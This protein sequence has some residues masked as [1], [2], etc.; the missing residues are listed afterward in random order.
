MTNNSKLIDATSRL[1]IDVSMAVYYL[2]F[3]TYFCVLK[4]LKIAISED[5]VMQ[6][7]NGSGKLVIGVADYNIRS[8]ITT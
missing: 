1:P 3:A 6:K 2:S 5:I 7:C 8:I 4:R